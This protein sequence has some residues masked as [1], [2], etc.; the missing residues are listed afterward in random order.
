[1]VRKKLMLQRSLL[2]AS[3]AALVTMAVAALSVAGG[4]AA[5]NSVHMEP[6]V[7]TVAPGGEVAV[8][9]AADV[10]DGL[11]AWSTTVSY[12]RAVVHLTHCAGQSFCNESSPG[13]VSIAGF[14]V[15]GISG[16]QTLQTLTFGAVGG[17]G[18]STALQLEVLT[19]AD[20][21]GPT[22]EQ[23][24][25]TPGSI[26][27]GPA[28]SSPT[29]QPEGT[30]YWGDVDCG[31]GVAIGDAQKVARSLIGLPV[32]RTAPC[33][34][35]GSN[36]AVDGTPRMWGDVDCGGGVAIGDAQKI[37]RSV[38]GLTVSQEAGCPKIGQ[39]LA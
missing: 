25:T 39:A 22:L 14:S 20:A 7:A 19:W 30:E 3:A 6:A 24:A 28:S 10:P 35:I 1:V 27:V 32:G 34:T 21:N 18:T 5:A 16:S 29:P 33:P 8:A 12:D 13:V 23:P 9:L 31:G 15:T 26:T 17:V 2:V 37:A 36:V 11:G 4:Q 38:I